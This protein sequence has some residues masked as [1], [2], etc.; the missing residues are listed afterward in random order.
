MAY[1]AIP[2]FHYFVG[3]AEPVKKHTGHIPC[4][5]GG[6][7]SVHLMP[8][9]QAERDIPHDI[10][11]FVVHNE[12]LFNI[13]CMPSLSSVRSMEIRTAYQVAVSVATLLQRSTNDKGHKAM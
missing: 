9:A 6:S 11:L 1:K 4:F 10:T 7:R 8:L 5:H 13:L 3:Y 2:I 12:D